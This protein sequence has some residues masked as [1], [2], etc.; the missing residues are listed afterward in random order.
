[1]L[2]GYN[3]LVK[4]WFFKLLVRIYLP[5]AKLYWFVFRP[6]TVGVKCV[7]RHGDKVLL[8]KNSY[9]L[10]L[11]TLPGGGVKRNE[12]IMDAVIR[13]VR[14]EVGITIN[15]PREC[16]SLFSDEDYKRSTTWIFTTQ[17]SSNRFE[18]DDLE[19]EE[20]KWFLKDELPQKKSHLLKQF[21]AL[22]DSAR[23]ADKS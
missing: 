3:C 2:V 13:E 8:I 18:I 16:G 10:K 7:L 12:S 14:E 1:M 6:K 11:W 21:L 22:A 23:K 17:V 9:G 20:A 19:V 5:L 4:R 15:D